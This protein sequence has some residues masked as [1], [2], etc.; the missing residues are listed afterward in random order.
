MNTKETLTPE[1]KKIYDSI[2]KGL[3]DRMMPAIKKEEEERK[4]Q[5]QKMAIE[6]Q[7]LRAEYLASLTPV[8]FEDFIKRIKILVE[9]YQKFLKYKKEQN[10][11]F[12]S[13]D[14]DFQKILREAKMA[15]G[16]KLAELLDNAEKTMTDMENITNIV[17][18]NDEIIHEEIEKRKR[19]KLLQRE[20][21]ERNS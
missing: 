15:D 5:L 19:L 4:I 16:L 21:H 6:Q 3:Y 10:I 9:R 18:K 20:K 13:L 14:I 1:E 2:I 17:G 7:R 12:C 11:L 8:S